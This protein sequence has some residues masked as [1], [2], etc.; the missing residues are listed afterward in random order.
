MTRGPKRHRLY[1]PDGERHVGVTT[2]AAD[3]PWACECGMSGQPTPLSGPDHLAAAAAAAFRRLDDGRAHA[4]AL[5][6]AANGT[7]ADA[8]GLLYNSRTWCGNPALRPFLR[9][10]YDGHG[11]LTARMDWPSLANHLNAGVIDAEPEDR[12][13]LRIAVSLAGVPIALCL[14]MLWRLDTTHARHVRDALLRQLPVEIE[15]AAR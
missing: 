9:P 15:E 13:V 8:M 1:R 11:S 12:L 3:E 5:V 10:F 6:G 2:P 4:M 7:D 14:S